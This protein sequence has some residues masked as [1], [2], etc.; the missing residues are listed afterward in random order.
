MTHTIPVEVQDTVYQQLARVAR[1]EGKT[2]EQLA[3][4]ALEQLLEEGADLR[5]SRRRL[6][7]YQRTGGIGLD[8]ALREAQQTWDRRAAVK[9]TT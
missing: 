2:V 8:H 7:E 4:G 5:L 3:L 6:A 9:P 1:T